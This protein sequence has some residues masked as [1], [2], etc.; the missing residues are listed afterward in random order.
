MKKEFENVL[1]FL[2]GY[3]QSKSHSQ[4]VLKAILPWQIFKHAKVIIPSRKWFSYRNSHSFLYLF[5]AQGKVRIRT[6]G[7]FF[8]SDYFLKNLQPKNAARFRWRADGR[9]LS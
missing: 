1:I 8:K 2:H 5:S 3:G 9:V 4:K 7:F 6:F